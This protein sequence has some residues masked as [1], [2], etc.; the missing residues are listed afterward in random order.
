MRRPQC[1]LLAALERWVEA[2][3][4]GPAEM[5]ESMDQIRLASPYNH[6]SRGCTETIRRGGG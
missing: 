1:L 3:L 2:M 5:P 6:R 4:A